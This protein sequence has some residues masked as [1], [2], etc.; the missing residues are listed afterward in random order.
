M[1]ERLLI[2]LAFVMPFAA[3]AAVAGPYPTPVEGDYTVKD[4]RFV[5]GEALPE[6]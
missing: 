5:S 4:F 6:L 3:P 2:A 1:F